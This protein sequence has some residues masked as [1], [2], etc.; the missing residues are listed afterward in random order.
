MGR[1]IGAL[2]QQDQALVKS[3]KGD[4]HE[5]HILIKHLEPVVDSLWGW[6]AARVNWCWGIYA[7]Q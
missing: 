1:Q 7:R 3:F 5:V 6:G 2:H 4:E